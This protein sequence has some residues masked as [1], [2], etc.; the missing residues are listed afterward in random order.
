MEVLICM[1]FWVLVIAGAMVRGRWRPRV[2]METLCLTCVNS[3]VTR[4]QSGKAMI[5]CR[6]GGVM[7]PVKFTVCQ[8]TGFCGV[9]VPVK[10]VKIEG[11]VREEREVYAEVEVR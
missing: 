8:C 9:A 3:V 10:L 7:R 5:A 2:A 6:L 4:G 1:V 11:F